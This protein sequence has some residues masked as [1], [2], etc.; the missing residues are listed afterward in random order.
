MKK[1]EELKKKI[2]ECEMKKEVLMAELEDKK[3]TLKRKLQDNLKINSEILR[4]KGVETKDQI[5]GVLRKKAESVRNFSRMAK[6]DRKNDSTIKL[7]ARKPS[8]RTE[9][10]TSK[11]PATNKLL[12]DECLELLLKNIRSMNSS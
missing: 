3:L 6:T 7:T 12:F 9:T 4:H 2:D 10:L 5:I 1:L 11:S 8:Y